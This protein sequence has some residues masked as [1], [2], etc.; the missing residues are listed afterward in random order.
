M[1]RGHPG[2]PKQKIVDLNNF[3]SFSLFIIYSPLFMLFRNTNQS[4][5]FLYELILS[6]NALI[7]SP[8]YILC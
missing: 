5:V 4:W 8:I 7:V 2:S 3:L 1:K 6:E